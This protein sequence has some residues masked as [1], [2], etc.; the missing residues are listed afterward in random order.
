MFEKIL[1]A[2]RGEIAC[3]VARAAR[4]LGVKTVA[5]FSDADANA[6]HVKAC[7]EA[8]RLGPAPARESYL[9]T[10]KVLAAA[11]QTGAQAIHPGYGFLSEQ[12]DFAQACADAGVV[13]IGPP[14]SAMRAIKDKAQGREVMRNAGVPVGQDKAQER[15]PCLALRVLARSGLEGCRPLRADLLPAASCGLRY[16]GPPPAS[17]TPGSTPPRRR[18]RRRGVPGHGALL[19]M[20]CNRA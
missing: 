20:G 13:F 12:A 1:I 5:V 18:L 7:D 15:L 11:K 16:D 9:D 8:V 6:L 4:A 2:N 10:A 17:A 3:R 19:G 14:P